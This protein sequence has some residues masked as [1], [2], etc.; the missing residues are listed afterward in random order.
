VLRDQDL[1]T[2]GPAIK[3]IGRNLS[4]GPLPPGT[5]VVNC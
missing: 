4:S 5:E 3:A 2:D 1:L